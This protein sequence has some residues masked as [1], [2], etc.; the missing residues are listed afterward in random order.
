MSGRKASFFLSLAALASLT[1]CAGGPGVQGPEAQ[2]LY[3]SYSGSWLLDEGSSSD[4]PAVTP[5]RQTQGGRA[6]GGG[7]GGGTRG[8]TGGGGTRG[9]G[10]RT[11]GG[12]GGT[13]GP[14]G[15]PGPQDNVRRPSLRD[16]F[17]ADALRA[18]AEIARAR[19]TKVELKLNDS[20][21]VV[22]YDTTV[23]AEA[24]MTGEDAEL[25]IAEFPVKANVS[26]K[27]GKPR[28][29]WKVGSGGEVIDRYEVLPTGRLAISRAYSGIAGDFEVRYVYSRNRA[30]A[31]TP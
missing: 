26:W 14:G 1:S 17:D 8:G 9:G 21:F 25:E 20:L 27:E 10:G 23:S 3:S 24:P 22:A 11:G 15:L 31:E 12:T 13:V 29:T 6:Q 16:I 5:P 2:T 19:P 28:L 7:G 18:V 30:T 4:A